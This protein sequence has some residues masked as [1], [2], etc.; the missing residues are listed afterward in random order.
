M[1]DETFDHRYASIDKVHALETRVAVIE[2]D[3]RNQLQ[4]IQKQNDRIE[5]RMSAPANTSALDQASLALQHLASKIA[6]PDTRP[7]S[8][9]LSHYLLAA[10]GGGIAIIAG[11]HQLGW[12]F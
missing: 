5:Q 12:H 4:N 11:M 1:T 8:N 3:I 7:Q 2:S 6:N 10:V 9:R